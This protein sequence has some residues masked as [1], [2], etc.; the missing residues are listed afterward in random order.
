MSDEGKVGVALT[1]CFYCGQ[2][3]RIVLNKYLTE[4]HAKEIKGLHGK[5][6]D[7]EPCSKCAEV[8]KQGIMLVVFD[9]DKSEPGWNAKGKI[10]NPWRTGHIAAITEE[11]F[12]QI[13]DKEKNKELYEYGLRHRFMF[14]E[15]EAAVK[16]GLI[17]IIE[18]KKEEPS[19]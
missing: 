9:P 13:V 2:P 18:D 15:Y 12:G 8:M 14:I 10:P 19:P 7:M 6:I 5:V 3:D 11:A 1:N 16:L 17:Q 4:R